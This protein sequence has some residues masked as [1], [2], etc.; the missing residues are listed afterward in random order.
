MHHVLDEDG[1]RLFPKGKRLISH[2]NLRDELKAQLRRRRTASPSS[3]MIVKVMERIVTQTIPA[4][5]IDNPRLD[6]NPFTN[7]VTAAPAADGRGRRAAADGR[8]PP[9][10]R[11]RAGRRATRSCWR[12]STRRAKADPYSPV[13]PTAIARASSSAPRCPRR[14]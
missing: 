7:A 3:G 10:R 9:T 11:A 6:W 14:G 1:E 12:T 5:V 2:W 13:A 4:A 8:R